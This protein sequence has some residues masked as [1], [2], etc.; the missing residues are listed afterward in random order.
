MLKPGLRHDT[1]LAGRLSGRITRRQAQRMFQHQRRAD[2]ARRT[3]DHCVFQSRR[4]RDAVF[5]ANAGHDD[6]LRQI[7][8]FPHDKTR[9]I[10]A[11][12]TQGHI[13]TRAR[14]SA[15]LSAGLLLLSRL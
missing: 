10:A 7:G 6:F 14:P 15:A 12:L 5:Q 13:A 2:P 9:I 1:P 8:V 3:D 4:R 11:M